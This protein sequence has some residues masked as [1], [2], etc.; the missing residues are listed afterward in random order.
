MRNTTKNKVKVNFK[1]SFNFN[2]VTRAAVIHMDK[3]L[4]LKKYPAVSIRIAESKRN[5]D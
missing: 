2:S 3:S 4:D 1:T 5:R